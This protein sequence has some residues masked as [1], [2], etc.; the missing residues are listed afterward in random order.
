MS[1]RIKIIDGF[2]SGTG[3]FLLLGA[4]SVFFGVWSR[5]KGLGAWCLATDEFYIA[6]AVE[7]IRETGIPRFP[8]GGIYGRGILFQYIE[9]LS[10]L[11]GG[12]NE[13]ALRLPAVLFGLACLPP[14]FLLARKRVGGTAAVLLISVFSL[15]LWEVEFARFAR[16]Y[17]AFLCAVTWFLY[18]YYEGFFEGRGRSIPWAYGVAV[19]AV[20]LHEAA[21]FIALL[22]WLPLLLP[23]A[24][25]YNLLRHAVISGI[26]LGLN[27]VVNVTDWVFPEPD[28]MA[29]LPIGF[30]NHH[31][32]IGTVIWPNLSLLRSL[33]ETGWGWKM[34]FAVLAFGAAAVLLQI[35]R[36]RTLDRRAKMVGGSLVIF[37]MLQMYGL[38]IFT[39]VIGYLCRFIRPSEFLKHR[40]MRYLLVVVFASLV[41]W[42]SLGLWTT[43]WHGSA[44]AGDVS[45]RKLLAVLFHYPRIG[46]KVLYEWWEVMPRVVAFT[47]ILAL[48]GMLLKGRTSVSVRDNFTFLILVVWVFCIGFVDTL[49]NSTRYSSFMYPLVLLLWFEVAADIASSVPHLNRA[50]FPIIH[51]ALTVL[52]VLLFMIGEDFSPAHLWTIDQA[53]VNFRMNQSEKVAAHY[54]ERY[55]FRTPAEYINE[56]F[57]PG[58][59]IVNAL[60][61]VSFYLKPVS[62][63]YYDDRRYNFMLISRVHGSRETWTGL[64]LIHTPESLQ[65][66]FEGSN[67]TIWMIEGKNSW[68]RTGWIERVRGTKEYDVESAMVSIDRRITVFRV[69]RKG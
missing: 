50:G 27:F 41:F 63:N 49:Y 43:Q 64:P 32:E 65:T 3:W 68:E 10:T 2:R 55:D 56:R 47:G 38:A 48:V 22:L 29:N 24:R 12:L 16:M 58:D 40:T 7:F 20:F 57:A 21:V 52:P 28:A 37:G 17:S 15:S 19:A 14:L 61:P 69:T 8:N 11:I 31:E 5:F 39:V 45:V 60:T 18:F 44:V 34:A 26:I 1:G 4:V 62:Y 67:G 33:S 46:E 35:V 23:L 59:L 9:T 36:V 30:E 54:Y 66:L 13:W 53:R 42:L 51:P 6:K 25:S